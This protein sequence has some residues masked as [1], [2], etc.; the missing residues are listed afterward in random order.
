M[1]GDVIK[2]GS[3]VLREKTRIDAQSLLRSSQLGETKPDLQINALKQSIILFPFICTSVQFTTQDIAACHDVEFSI[4]VGTRGQGPHR[5]FRVPI[6]VRC[7]QS[8]VL[9]V[10][11]FF[12]VVCPHGAVCL[13]VCLSGLAWRSDHC[14]LEAA[15]RHGGSPATEGRTTQHRPQGGQA[16]RAV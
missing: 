2:C 3:N 6:P 11:S 12:S 13:S 15:A 4:L 1:H 8:V 16:S 10:C 9:S 14:E 7:R 5:L